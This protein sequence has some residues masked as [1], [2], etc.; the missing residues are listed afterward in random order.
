MIAKRVAALIT[1]V[2]TML[3]SAP[4]TLA[5]GNDEPASAHERIIYLANND[6]VFN[7]V[8]VKNPEYL[9]DDLKV[10]YS[11][12]DGT[13]WDEFEYNMD[14]NGVMGYIYGGSGNDL[15]PG[16]QA[17]N[18]CTY[19]EYTADQIKISS[20]TDDVEPLIIGVYNADDAAPTSD[21]IKNNNS[22]ISAVGDNGEKLF[23]EEVYN[24]NRLNNK[25]NTNPSYLYNADV[26]GNI[27]YGTDGRDNKT[28][29]LIIN[30]GGEK[31][32]SKIGF[33]NMIANNY[34]TTGRQI[35]DKFAAYYN[36]DGVWKLIDEVD[37]NTD[38]TKFNHAAITTSAV[39][40]D[41][42]KLTFTFNGNSNGAALP[43]LA[44][45]ES[46]PAVRAIW[47]SYVGIYD[48]GDNLV[49]QDYAYPSESIKLGDEN[50]TF[51]AIDTEDDPMSEYYKWQYSV[52]DA[53]WT[54]Y[55]EGTEVS[56]QYIRIIS[57]VDDTDIPAFE[58]KWKGNLV[59]YAA[60]GINSAE[61]DGKLS[62][63]DPWD[64][65]TDGDM[66]TNSLLVASD[67][68]GDITLDLKAP[69]KFYSMYG[70]YSSGCWYPQE[71]TV[72]ISNKGTEWVKAAAEKFELRKNS[73]GVHA[74]DS[75][76]NSAF[77]HET[78]L[79]GANAAMIK[80]EYRK[81]MRAACTRDENYNGNEIRITELNINGSVILVK[82]DGEDAVRTEPDDDPPVLSNYSNVSE[83]VDLTK[84]VS[85][86]KFTGKLNPDGSDDFKWQY[87]L[88]GE[89]WNELIADTQTSARY[90]RIAAVSQDTTL[91]VPD[92]SLSWS[93][94]LV[95]YAAEGYNGAE[96]TGSL[97]SNDAWRYLYDGDTTG[98]SGNAVLG[99]NEQRGDLTFNFNAPAVIKS[100][101]GY[102]GPGCWYPSSYTVEMSNDG[103]VWTPAAEEKF[104]LRRNSSGEHLTTDPEH[105]SAFDHETF[106]D[107]TSDDVSAA[108]I[109][110]KFRGSMRG[111]C[112]GNDTTDTRICELVLDGSIDIADYNGSEVSFNTPDKNPPEI[113]RETSKIFVD[114]IE[115]DTT[116]RAAHISE[117]T[118]EISGE[119]ISE[120]TNG[121]AYLAVYENDVLKSVAVD[122]EPDSYINKYE[123]SLT[124]TVPEFNPTLE[125]KLFFWDKDTQ[126]P[127]H[128][129]AVIKES[130]YTM[131]KSE[132][133][134]MFKEGD[135][136]GFIGDSITHADNMNTPNYMSFIYDYYIT[137][138]PNEPIKMI[139]LGIA[140]YTAGDVLNTFNEN[141]AVGGVRKNDG[142]A[143]ANINKAT[144]M[145][146]MN[147]ISRGLYYKNNMANNA[148]QR[149]TKID[150][151]NANTREILSRLNGIGVKNTD[152]TIITPSIFD[153]TKVSNATSSNPVLAND[154][155]VILAEK[156]K[157]LAA[158]KGTN[159]V[160]FNAPM[161]EINEAYQARNYD[162][163][164]IRDDLVHPRGMG[165]T[166]MGYL[167]LRQQG[168]DSDVA[169]VDLTNDEYKNCDV[170]VK[171]KYANYI[172]YTYTPKSIP[173]AASSD[174]Q[175]ANE[176]VAITNDLNREIIKADLHDGNYKLSIDGVELGTFT[177]EAFA[178]GVNIAALSK[179]PNQIISQEIEK[180]NIERRNNEIR[181]RNTWFQEFNKDTVSYYN[182]VNIV[183]E[184]D[185]N[186]GRFVA[187]PNYKEKDEYK[188]A[189]QADKNSM[190]TYAEV[191]LNPD[192]FINAID[193]CI[194]QMYKK[195]QEA[196]KT[197]H[198]VTI[199]RVGTSGEGIQLPNFF[200]ENMVLQRGK[201]HTIWGQGRTGAEYNVTLSNGENT[202]S[203]KTSADENGEWKVDL[204]SLPVS[205]KSYTLTVEGD[206]EFISVEGIKIG[207]VYFVAGQS[208]IE[209][210]VKHLQSEI[211]RE[212]GYTMDDTPTPITNENISFINLSTTGSST[213]TFDIKY[214]DNMKGWQPL[215]DSNK[216][217]LSFIAMFFADKMQKAENVPI[218]LIS[219]PWGGTRIDRW[220]A[221]GY[222]NSNNIYNNHVYPF[223]NY[224]INGILWYQGCSD[225]D[226]DN[227]LAGYQNSFPQLIDDWRADWGD[228]T[229]PFIYAQLARYDKGNFMRIREA[230]RTAPDK[231]SHPENVAMITTIDTDKGT[232]CNIHPL[233]KDMIADRFYNA[234][235]NIIFGDNTA[236]E[237]P[238]FESA[239]PDG[240]KMIVNFKTGTADGLKIKNP[241]YS[242]AQDG[243]GCSDS[244]TLNEF[245]IA[246]DDMNF[247]TAKAEIVGNTVE[248][249][250]SAVKEPKYVR[251]AYSKSPV[252]PNLY[253][254]ADLPCSPFTSV[255]EI[256]V[257]CI[258]D[259]ITEG[260]GVA[261]AEDKYTARLER[262]LN[263]ET[264]SALNLS[265]IL[266]TFF[267]KF[268]N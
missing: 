184:Y 266:D 231:V 210:A 209:Q 237:G 222:Q 233:G 146:G 225:A 244:T 108:M 199:E 242:I 131:P 87:S 85:F 227:W 182:W 219:T 220:S 260:I 230:Q 189:S 31:R 261:K 72:E 190:D 166:M 21:Q 49:Y 77:D 176:Y 258:G 26:N 152:I 101:H 157:E 28:G 90:I 94:N 195:A 179:N 57:S 144:I 68:T 18:Y 79:G 262:M 183:S 8:V 24:G 169:V 259:S 255:K 141:V 135:V 143:W 126:A 99:A 4:I 78:N 154:G 248:V 211:E 81:S 172:E 245:E 136:V 41:K 208:N 175:A 55:E 53:D 76:H 121:T 216:N 140:S 224:K 80:I 155:L 228:E 65:I 25:S 185:E 139:N 105:Y 35:G 161:L 48:F 267:S 205:D 252:N 117:G 142:S 114:G 67:N 138:K 163:T 38:G 268:L 43:N 181:I 128:E 145:I 71:Y 167:F 109:K 118:H 64:T 113:T 3:G 125:I 235:R 84:V 187:D 218:G 73:S 265:I 162:G 198:T 93:G 59:Q 9:P 96:K 20:D 133:N 241:D 74:D 110:L 102:Y 158:E 206:G 256:N 123:P 5:N 69:A 7:H 45:G 104:Q 92:F 127:L 88:D 63:D 47:L 186:S 151:S 253:N 254:G 201:V 86:N 204:S 223:I 97:N 137:R 165:H 249:S 122:S 44:E 150:E 30:L 153:N 148:E 168:A 37:N 51:N 32:I 170:D 250:A 36:K 264:D 202:S 13:T 82:Y 27:L 192:K 103:N 236:Y 207:D 156:D 89:I 134:S 19:R 124:Y 243:S 160:E 22:L 83:P 239:V 229:L 100:L 52:D 234:A 217:T 247:V 17:G 15:I 120:N 14:N 60:N 54:D 112:D 213:R 16:S 197:T 132:N 39:R 95:E 6:S 106:F 246:G 196:V 173:L 119:I 46:K 75:S 180:L 193:D 232:S 159:L 215:N 116:V 58:L 238:M 191:K 257:V 221:T 66:G 1:A 11:N 50:I 107:G 42:V 98:T 23:M 214:A 263:D 200:T 164:I 62:G 212:G 33:G 174:Y 188:N 194:D 115:L 34:A 203:G 177:D 12:D 147:D 149:Q 2:C 61:I 91:V 70:Y 178:A 171:T 40:T 111:I 226:N 129:P 130:L 10:E 251:Y 240:N 56:A 29:S